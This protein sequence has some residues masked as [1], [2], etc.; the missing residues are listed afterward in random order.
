MN[1]D[2]SLLKS[3]LEKKIRDI[4]SNNFTEDDHVRLRDYFLHDLTNNTNVE[5]QDLKKYLF[6]GFF[7]FHNKD[8]CQYNK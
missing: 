6:A 1:R 5:D 7:L 4:E 3:F 8:F 2:R